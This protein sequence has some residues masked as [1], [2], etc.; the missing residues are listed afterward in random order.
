MPAGREG[1]PARPCGWPPPAPL[2]LHR[3]APPRQT[4]SRDDGAGGRALADKSWG[5]AGESDRGGD[6]PA[7]AA[8]RAA[9]RL[10]AFEDRAQARAASRD[11]A[12][13]ERERAR[14]ARRAE[15]QAA[16][17]EGRDGEMPR[18]RRSGR[19]DVVRVQRDTRGYQTVKDV[20]RI[21]EL[22]RRG[23]SLAGLAEA[24]G[25]SVEEVEGALAEAAPA[26]R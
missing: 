19:T 9:E 13:Q 18:R 7:S 4:R 5:V 25:M 15:E 23:A 16:R 11:A 10:K 1:Y 2:R 6:R 26:D 12:A 22:A 8:H 3:Q 24:F 17:A 14:E 20:E 21:R